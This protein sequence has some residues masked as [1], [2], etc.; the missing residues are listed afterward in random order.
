MREALF[1]LHA[2]LSPGYPVGAYTY[3]HGLEWA[4]GAGDVADGASTQAWVRD[5]LV[6]GAGRSDAILLAHA[7]RA[8]AAGNVAGDRAAL[9]DLAEL[10]QA[11]APSAERL[12][13]TEAQ[14]AAFA[15][16]TASAW[17]GA[18]SMPTGSA[19]YPVAVGRA[20]AAHGV[21]LPETLAVFLQAFVA[22]LV[23]AAV[24]LV[25]LGQTEG[26]QILAD[27]MADVLAVAAEAEGADLD[28]IGGFSF[29][30][31]IAS[32][33]HETQ[34]VRLFRT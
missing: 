23:S 11:L 29:G 33:R 9:D 28:Q 13:E 8:G 17:G 21:A 18:A 15:G 6:Q 5:C 16:V 30:A 1:K 3:S 27:L 20:A 22:N 4:V 32:M 14:G 34:E 19:P 24:R 2:W 31:D 10:A 25:P 7:W 12:L 26:Q